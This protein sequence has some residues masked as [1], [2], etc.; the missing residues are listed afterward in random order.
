MKGYLI[1]LINKLL[2]SLFFGTIIVFSVQAAT[3][4]D[5]QKCESDECFGLLK[6]AQRFARNGNAHAQF[7]VGVSLIN[8][9]GLDKNLESGFRYL[10]RASNAG[11]A[12]ATYQLAV[13][14]RTGTNTEKNHKLYQHYLQQAVESGYKHAQ[15]EMAVSLFHAKKMEKAKKLLLYSAQQGHMP[16]W[17]LLGRILLSERI[18]KGQSLDDVALIFY[19]LKNIE[20][21]DSAV[22]YSF[23]VAQQP[24]AVAYV[25]KNRNTLPLDQA[26]TV[27]TAPLSVALKQ[28][29]DQEEQNSL[30]DGNTTGTHIQGKACTDM[31]YQC[32]QIGIAEWQAL[33]ARLLTP[34]K[35]AEGTRAAN[36]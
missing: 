12:Q 22:L 35:Y 23:I 24:S 6:K 8:G 5:S 15:Y 1:M 11:L 10:K 19:Q 3:N 4:V 28:F 30:M 17:Y 7:L 32:T 25:E 14:Y 33:E 18:D 36:N 16:S 26:A 2:V 9:D 29:I 31:G 21:I 27:K 20:F 34:A 13:E